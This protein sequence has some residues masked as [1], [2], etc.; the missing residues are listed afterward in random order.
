MGSND[1]S[2]NSDAVSSRS[3]FGDVVCLYCYTCVVSVCTVYYWSGTSR[4]IMLVKISVISVVKFCGADDEYVRSSCVLGFCVSPC[5]SR[6]PFYLCKE[7]YRLMM[8]QRTWAPWRSNIWKK[9]RQ[10]EDDYISW[11]KSPETQ[12]LTVSAAMKRKACNKS[13]WKAAKQ[14]KDWG[15]RRRRGRR[16]RRRLHLTGRANR[17]LKHS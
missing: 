4:S 1:I 2:T 9:R 14:S 6:S 5:C 11:S 13:R 7:Q 3:V 12:E 17:G 15:I 16:R 10:W 8:F